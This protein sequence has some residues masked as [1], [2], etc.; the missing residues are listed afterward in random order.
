MYRAISLDALLF[1]QPANPFEWIN[2]HGWQAV[3][4]TRRRALA[5][6]LYVLENARRGRPIELYAD[7]KYCWLPAATVAALEA[8]AALSGANPVLTLQQESETPIVKSVVFDR[9]QGPLAF[10][11]VDDFGDYFSGTLYLIEV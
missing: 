7:P 10:E 9:S 2:E 5:G 6:N 11:P 4:Q 8:M 3:G 1:D